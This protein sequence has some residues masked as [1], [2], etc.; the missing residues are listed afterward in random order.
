MSEIKSK[1]FLKRKVKEEKVFE[2]KGTFASKHEAEGWLSK[3]GYSYGS[4][5]CSRGWDKD[6][7]PPVPIRKGEYDLPQKW[8]NLS[9]EG[10]ESLDGVMISS[11]WREGA[12][13][14]ILFEDKTIL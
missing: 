6:G 7:D 3:N 11:D 2:S 4:T 1:Y 5:S 14:V 12:V 10:K 9:R 13:K 8:H